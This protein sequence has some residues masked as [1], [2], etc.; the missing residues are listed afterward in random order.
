MTYS[1]EEFIKKGYLAE[2]TYTE[3]DDA[4]FPQ[5]GAIRSLNSWLMFMLISGAEN[6]QDHALAP[7]MVGTAI[8]IRG[9]NF[10]QSAVLLTQRAMMTPARV[11]V[12]CLIED[13]VHLAALISEP[14]QIV[15]RLRDDNALSRTGMAKV[16]ISVLR[17]EEKKLQIQELAGLK[18]LPRPEEIKKIAAI[19]GL[20]QNYIYYRYYSNLATH[21]TADSLSTFMRFDENHSP[22]G[23]SFDEYTI[24]EVNNFLDFLIEF[25]SQLGV[26][27]NDL[28]SNKHSFGY[29]VLALIDAANSA[30]SCN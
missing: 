1:K 18:K 25:A 30:K 9:V 8:L 11:M 21:T 13:I 2:F 4:R 27:Y 24:V 20:E 29:D 28:T 19:S 12:R 22:V 7:E 6:T 17:D 23:F 16:L 14:E 26:S 15:Q 5:Y 10:L 3:E